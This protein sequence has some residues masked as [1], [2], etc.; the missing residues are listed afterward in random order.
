MRAVGQR[1]IIGKS[2]VNKRNYYL[3]QL[4]RVVHKENNFLFG[5]TV[6][7]PESSEEKDAV[8]K[9]SKKKLIVI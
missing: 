1:A 7:F 4:E 3:V 8:V 5:K 9:C 6:K 2:A